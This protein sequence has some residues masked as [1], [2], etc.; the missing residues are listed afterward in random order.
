MI[1]GRCLLEIE[2]IQFFSRKKNMDTM[3][4][5]MKITLKQIIIHWRMDKHRHIN[6]VL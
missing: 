5:V 6:E 4:A 3:L 2:S 1:I